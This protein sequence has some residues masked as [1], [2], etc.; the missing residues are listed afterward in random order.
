MVS[1]RVLDFCINIFSYEYLKKK[2]TCAD[3]KGLGCATNGHFTNS[4][5]SIVEA[6]NVDLQ[7][8]LYSSFNKVVKDNVT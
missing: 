7:S 5:R 1:D 4:E 2:E 3:A 8:D 6:A